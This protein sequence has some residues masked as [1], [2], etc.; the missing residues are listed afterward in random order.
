MGTTRRT[1][2]SVSCSLKHVTG[3]DAD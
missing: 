3:A 1:D 2:N